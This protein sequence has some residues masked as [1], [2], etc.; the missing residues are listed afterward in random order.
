MTKIY[1]ILLLLTLTI[2]G[3]KNPGV[4]A[5]EAYLAEGIRI[6]EN[7]TTRAKVGDKLMYVY[8]FS[9]GVEPIHYTYTHIC[10]DTSML[11]YLDNEEFYLGERNMAG[12]PS[13][14]I[15][16][17]EATK[18]GLVKI[19][20]YNPHYNLQL[21]EQEAE[22]NPMDDRAA[23]IRDYYA[24]LNRP[25]PEEDWTAAQIKA[26]EAAWLEKAEVELESK[27]DEIMYAHAQK[28][29]FHTEV[30][31]LL[32]SLYDEYP[33]HKKEEWDQVREKYE[34]NPPPYKGIE[35]FSCYIEI[36]N[37]DN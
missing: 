27:I 6:T 32:D 9:A 22:K 29:A 10:S 33:F 13:T 18:A 2:V 1:S 16:V 7:D 36:T 34:N 5:F 25:L 14:G 31:A 19:E 35:V 28:Y 21:Y 20:F 17:F 11:N 8:G 24:S 3:C 37:L 26:A 4:K 30:H 23:V 15:H 12:G